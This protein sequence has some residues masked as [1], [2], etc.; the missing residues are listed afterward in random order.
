MYKRRSEKN[1]KRNGKINARNERLIKT[2]SKIVVTKS[3]MIISNRDKEIII[4]IF[5]IGTLLRFS[6]IK[7]RKNI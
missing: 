1:W 4:I 5:I 2:N 7:G 3:K 6:W